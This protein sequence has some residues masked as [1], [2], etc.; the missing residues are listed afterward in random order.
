[1][2]AEF[3]ARIGPRQDRDADAACRHEVVLNVDAGPDAV[4]ASFIDVKQSPLESLI[5][6][7]V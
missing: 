2:R 3:L 7:F 5:D 1:L 4:P 6:S